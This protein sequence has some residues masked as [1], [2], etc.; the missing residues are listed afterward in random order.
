MLYKISNQF[1]SN[2]SVTGHKGWMRPVIQQRGCRNTATT[3]KVTHYKDPWNISQ[4]E[5]RSRGTSNLFCSMNTMSFTHCGALKHDWKLRLSSCGHTHLI[6]LY[7]SY[8]CMKI[9]LNSVILCFIVLETELGA[10][11][12]PGKTSTTELYP[13]EFIILYSENLAN[14]SF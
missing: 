6:L 8:W 10:S 14:C 3:C 5:V 4:A 13:Q 12:T 7:S 1:Y 2:P 11:H 9:T